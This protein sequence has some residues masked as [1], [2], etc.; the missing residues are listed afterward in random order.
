MR[1][2]SKIMGVKLTTKQK[3][4]AKFLINIS[5]RDTKSELDSKKKKKKPMSHFQK[6]LVKT[7]YP[8]SC[9]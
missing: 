9:K 6:K 5:N 3:R 4:I 7:V 2:S 1:K 8:Q